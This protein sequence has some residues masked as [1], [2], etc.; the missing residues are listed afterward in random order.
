MIKDKKL[1]EKFEVEFTRNENL[2]I[3]QKFKILEAMLEEAKSFGV[4]PPKDPLE[5]IEVDIKLARAINA[6]QRTPREN[7]K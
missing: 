4:W 2:T 3:E 5:G 7:S 6:I 1:W